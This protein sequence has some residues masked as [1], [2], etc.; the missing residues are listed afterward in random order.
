VMK[1]FTEKM[2]EHPKVLNDKSKPNLDTAGVKDE[3]GQLED[4]LAKGFQ[5]RSNSVDTASPPVT[6]SKDDL[7]EICGD[8][9]SVSYK[10]VLNDGI[11]ANDKQF[12]KQFMNNL[13][14]NHEKIKREIGDSRGFR[15]T[16]KNNSDKTG[17][18]RYIPERRTTLEKPECI[19]LKIPTSVKYRVDR[20][21]RGCFLG[22]SNTLVH[23]DNDN[24]EHKTVWQQVGS[25]VKA[26][27]GWIP[28]LHEKAKENFWRPV[29]RG[30]LA[31]GKAFL[32]A[33]VNSYPY[34]QQIPRAFFSPSFEQMVWSGGINPYMM[35][36][37]MGMGMLGGGMA[38]G[39]MMPYN[40]QGEWGGWGGLGALGGWGGLIGLSALGA[41]GA[42]G[43]F[44]GLGGF[45]GFGGLDSTGWKI[46]TYGNNMMPNSADSSNNDGTGWKIPAYYGGNMMP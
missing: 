2:L 33:S 13:I 44:G 17:I 1:K 10:D 32:N 6:L 39:N 11:Y 25:G 4:V 38:W 46:P 31:G 36:M 45:G 3:L 7:N 29:G 15:P 24:C 26:S 21:S 35:A 16:W 14:E 28:P 43:G 40:S 23:Y 5:F 12:M 37:G 30:I 22:E 8:I 20:N 27:V 9:Y 41:L 18:K 19:E 42:W 34:L